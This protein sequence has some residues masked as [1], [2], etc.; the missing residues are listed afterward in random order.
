MAGLL[1]KE[2]RK[3]STTKVK[4]NYVVL[5]ITFKMIGNVKER[6]KVKT[7]DQSGHIIRVF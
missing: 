7:E 1:S 2:V 3:K 4:D 6:I 5:R